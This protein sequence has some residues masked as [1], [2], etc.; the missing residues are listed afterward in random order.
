MLFDVFGRMGT[1]VRPFPVGRHPF[2]HAL[3]C[4]VLVV[5]E[6]LGTPPISSSS[7]IQLH[8]EPASSR[9]RSGKRGQSDDE[10]ADHSKFLRNT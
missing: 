7:T 8:V 4:P 10:D 3:K 2:Q 1:I 9:W 5:D 6:I